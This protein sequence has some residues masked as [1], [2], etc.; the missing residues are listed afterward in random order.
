[1]RDRNHK[2]RFSASIRFRL[3]PRMEDYL[4]DYVR[5]NE[6]TMSA[7]LRTAITQMMRNAPEDFKRTA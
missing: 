4:N 2:G 1:M 3:T 7:V 6:T 5:E